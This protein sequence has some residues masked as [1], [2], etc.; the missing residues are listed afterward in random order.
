MRVYA[1]PNDISQKENSIMLLKFEL[2]YNN[3]VV[4]HVNQN[5]IFIKQIYLISH[6]PVQ[7][8]K[9]SPNKNMNK[10]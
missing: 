7:K 6:K 9:K 5:N 4:Q 2:T 3:F 10:K 1:F 8:K